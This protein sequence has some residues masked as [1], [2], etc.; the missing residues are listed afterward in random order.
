MPEMSYPSISVVVPSFNQGQYLEETI[1]SVIG[2]QY[3]SL[4][5]IVID[6]GS[7]DNSVEIIEKY[8]ENIS[9]WHSRKDQGQGDAINQGMGRSSGDVVCWLNSDDMYLPGTLLDVGR[10][11]QGHTDGYHLIYGGAI[12]L[13]QHSG[14]LFCQG[15]P[16]EAFDP[17]KLTYWDFIIQPSS[18]W[19]R[20]L[21]KETGNINVAYNYVLDWDWFV[22][23][24]KL[25]SF[26]YVPRFYSIYR[27]HPLHKTGGGGDERRR[28][29][30]DI[31]GKYSSDYWIYLFTKVQQKY[32]S[33]V[34]ILT[35]LH[36]L[37]IPRRNTIFLPLFLPRLR[38]KLKR[39]K[40]FFM[41]LNMYQPDL[42]YLYKNIFTK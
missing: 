9:Y 22:R 37:K 23:A 4:E 21:W 11:F 2:Q 39:I 33:I 15:Q 16:A 8:S 24:S 5:L 14:N 10:R 38:L 20:K 30:C 41:V 31:V 32:D 1:L 19:T 40:D 26:E 29:I 18:F 42:F 25:T 7:T 6:G 17:I 27:F 13:G 34:K 35:I 12:E 36:A 28:E 3:P